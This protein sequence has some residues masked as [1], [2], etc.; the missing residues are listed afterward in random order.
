MAVSQETKKRISEIEAERARLKAQLDHTLKQLEFVEKKR[1]PDSQPYI[2]LK[3]AMEIKDLAG[4]P[5]GIRA[6]LK[7][8][9]ERLRQNIEAL[10]REATEVRNVGVEEMFR[11]KREAVR[12]AKLNIEAH[13]RNIMREAAIKRGYLTTE[14][15]AEVQAGA[16]VTLENC[17]ELL[18]DRPSEGAIRDVLDQLADTMALGM[19]GTDAQKNAMAGVQTAAQKL[20]ERAKQDFTAVPTSANMRKLLGSAAR[21]AVVGNEASAASAIAEFV[22]WAE[23]QRDLAEARFRKTPTSENFKTLFNLEANCIRVGGRPMPERP[24]GL[25]RVKDGD[26]H[27][28]AP[29]E[30][31]S[32]VSQ[33]YYGNFSY[34]DVIARANVDLIKDFDFPPAGVTLNVP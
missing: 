6:A 20:V 15:L 27:K 31:L 34:W 16:E 1:I 2:S 23:K 5:I 7:Q 11:R 26:S 28:L 9:I 29:G 13:A 10:K 22:P 30:S 8:D 17:T 12:R 19:E 14:E 3:R 18:G 24:A 32:L 33:T 21:A 4:P 25:Q